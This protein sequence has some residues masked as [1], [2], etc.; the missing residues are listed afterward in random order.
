V[1]ALLCATCAPVQAPATNAT[2]PETPAAAAPAEPSPASP[3]PAQDPVK[4]RVELAIQNVRDRDLL[5]TNGF[6]TIFHGILG[7]GPSVTLLE[8]ESGRKLNAIDYVCDGG[9]LRGLNFVPTRYGLDVQIGPFMVGQG[10]QDQFI[11][12]MAQWGMPADRT[13]MVLGKKYSYMD[14]VHHAQMRARLNQNQELS[15]TILVVGQYLG[16]DVSWTNGSGERLHYQ[17]LLRYELDLPVESAACGGTHRLFDLAWVYQLHKLHDGKITGAWLEIPTVTAKYRD[18]AHKYQNPDGSFS[19][20]FFRGAGNA[21][22]KQLRI[23]TTGHTLEWLALA[24]PETELKEPWVQA[25]ANALALMILEQRDSP[26]EG[27]SLYHAVHGLILYHARVYGN[28]FLGPQKP[29][30]PNVGLGVQR[31]APPHLVKPDP[32]KTS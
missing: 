12:E 26:I 3:E 16:T 19:T 18:L 32:G 24:L 20:N 14:F 27:G 31:L 25:A 22:D 28:D 9:D 15:W 10:H 2:N 13:F 7:L 11:A 21:S 5:V 23:N 8:P 6:W 1:A 4:Q 17:D 29:V 30:L